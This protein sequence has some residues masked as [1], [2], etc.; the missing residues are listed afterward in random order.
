MTVSAQFSFLRLL[1]SAWL[2]NCPTGRETLSATS[3]I[4]HFI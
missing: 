1:H 3:A 4:S 2:S